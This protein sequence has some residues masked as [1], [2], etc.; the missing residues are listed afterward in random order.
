VKD[1]CPEW[2]VIPKQDESPKFGYML[3]RKV[4]IK[5]RI[6]L[7]FGYRSER[8]IEKFLKNAAIFWR[9]APD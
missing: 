9:P 8:K 4:G 2:P 5:L 7:Y 3:E 1:K 6:L